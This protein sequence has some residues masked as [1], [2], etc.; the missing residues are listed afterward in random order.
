MYVFEI[1]AQGSPL[2][3]MLIFEIPTQ[4]FPVEKMSNLWNSYTKVPLIK[5]LIFEIPTQNIKTE[6]LYKAGP[7]CWYFKN[8]QFYKGDPCV[9]ISKINIFT[10]G[11]RCAGISKI[12]NFVRSKEGYLEGV[13]GPGRSLDSFRISI[14]LSKASLLKKKLTKYMATLTR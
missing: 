3:N 7:L 4:G 11:D 5:M 6:N 1:P 2:V 13:W 14:S 8:G 12:C 10:R 9:G